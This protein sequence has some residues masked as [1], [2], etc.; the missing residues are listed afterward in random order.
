M[1]RPL[2]T[3]RA[4]GMA[5]WNAAIGRSGASRARAAGVRARRVGTNF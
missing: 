5:W 1:V 3:D 4:S 2:S